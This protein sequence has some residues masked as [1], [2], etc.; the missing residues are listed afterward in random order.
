MSRCY[1]YILKCSDGTYYT[2][3]TRYLKERIRKH[4]TG[5]AANYTR[6]KRPVELVY[7]E[8]F[9]R[10]DKAFDREKQIQGWSRAKKEALVHGKRDQLPG[11]ARRGARRRN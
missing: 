6:K 7:Y 11:L 2:G 10:I 1:V 8:V 9:D 4:Q 5:E 3:S